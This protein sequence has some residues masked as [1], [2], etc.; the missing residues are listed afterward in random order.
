MAGSRARIGHLEDGRSFLS[1][2]SRSALGNVGQSNYSA[3]K[4]GVL[5]LTRAAAKE[6]G[7]YNVRVNA[8][9][10][11]A[12]TR[13]IEDIP[14]GQRRGR[15]RFGPG[16]R[17]S[18]LSERRLDPRGHR[19]AVHRRDRT[20]TV[21]R[22]VR[23]R[24]LSR[25]VEITR[26][27]RG[28]SRV[29]GDDGRGPRRRTRKGRRI[30]ASDRGRQS[31]VPRRGGRSQTGLRDGSGSADVHPDGLFPA[32]PSDGVGLDHGFDLGFDQSRVVHGEQEYVYERPVYTGTF[33]PVKRRS[34]TSTSGPAPGAGR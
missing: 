18:R 33:S 19:R 16:G 20:R 28:A 26:R 22:Q 11:T 27:A 17:P 14:D 8:L 9:V 29:D 13:M 5:G 32:K 3:A 30:R 31:G 23:G 2:S 7:R 12:Y 15:L 1:V 10:P 25:A 34:R 21:P 24:V 4:A 6:L